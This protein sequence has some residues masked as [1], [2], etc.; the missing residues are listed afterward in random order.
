[1]KTPIEDVIKNKMSGF[2]YKTQSDWNVFEKKLP[3]KKISLYKYLAIGAAAA[4]VIGAT[5]IML[6]SDDAIPKENKVNIADKVI[7]VNETTTNNNQIAEENKT[8]VKTNESKT[9]II[10]DIIAEEV[11]TD[12]AVETTNKT[13][14]VIPDE[15]TEE[16][17]AVDNKPEAIVDEY[18]PNSSFTASNLKG[19]LPFNSNF[20]ANDNHADVSYKW[21]F[22]DGFK[23]K[24]KTLNHIFKKAG[25]Y[26]VKLTTKYLKNNKTNVSE[27]QI[28][29][30]RTPKADFTYTIDEE[31]YYFDG[32]DKY[33]LVW[34]FG[35]NSIS[36]DIDPEHVYKKIGK[37]EVQLTVKNQY[38]CSASN[39]ETIKITPVYK[40]ANAFSP[41]NN[42]YNDSF[43]PIF[44]YPEYYDYELYIY[45]SNGKLVFKSQLKNQSWNGKTN[46]SDQLAEKGFYLWKL[47]I[48]DKYGNKIIEKGNLNIT[49]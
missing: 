26:T 33:E 28:V 31:V 45:N 22:S 19:C 15:K 37:T 44:E 48:Q 21:E 16:I 14:D 11:K 30:N 47:V 27:Q 42:G 32:P 34:T 46:N 25:K 23:S 6:N 17:V 49:N 13:I 7:I 18:S 3:K 9:G 5:S 8:E 36:S 41:D 38:G 43:G 4:L 10:K 29:V 39:K 20:T 1:M 24:D 40:I 12:K 2:E 35:D